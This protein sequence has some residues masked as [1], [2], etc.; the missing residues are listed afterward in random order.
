MRVSGTEIRR[1][2]FEKVV[3]NSGAPKV[4]KQAETNKKDVFG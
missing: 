2:S 3:L 1:W 4:P